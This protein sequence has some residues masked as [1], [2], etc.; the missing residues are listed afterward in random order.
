M[1]QHYRRPLIIHADRYPHGAAQLLAWDCV[2]ASAS[3]ISTLLLRAPDAQHLLHE[4]VTPIG[5]DRVVQL[6]T[7]TARA[8]YQRCPV[9]VAPFEQAGDERA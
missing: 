9:H 1:T 5:R 3:E 2:A 8:T 6:D 7:R 4:H